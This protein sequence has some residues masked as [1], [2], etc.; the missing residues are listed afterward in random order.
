MQTTIGGVHRAHQHAGKRRADLPM[1]RSTVGIMLACA[2]GLVVPWAAVAQQPTQVP[3]IGVLMPARNPERTQ[4]LEAFRHS[5]RD[6]GWVEGQNLAMEYRFAE[7]GLEQYPALAADLVRLKVDVLVVGGAAVRAAKEATSTIPIVM[8]SGG[9]ALEAGLIDSLAKPGGNLTG[10]VSVQAELMARRLTIL[11]EAL[12]GV[13][14]L[15]V[16]V[17]P[18]QRGGAALHETQRTAEAMGMALHVQE[19]SSPDEFPGAYAAMQQAGAEALLVF[20]DS[21]LLERHVPTLTALAL[22]HR[23]PVMYAHRMYVDAGGLMYYGTNIRDFY[24]RTAYYVDRILKGTKPADLPVEMPWKF[25]LVLNLKTAQALGL[26]LPPTL[27]FQAD[28][29]IQ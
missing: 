21:V 6:L 27:L 4:N 13:S 24:R 14:R 11:Q 23:L 18:R 16:L 20:A 2:L 19:V 9:G 10:T 22:Q 12:P 8:V 1:W 3:R 28:E 15:A 7:H 29:V 25:E 17:T 26:T 5:L